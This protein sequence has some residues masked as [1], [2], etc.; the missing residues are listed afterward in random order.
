ME[1]SEL[2]LWGADQSAYLADLWNSGTQQSVATACGVS[3]QVPAKSHQIERRIGIT[4][5]PLLTTTM[6]LIAEMEA[7][8][9]CPAGPARFYAQS[10]FFNST[11]GQYCQMNLYMDGQQLPGDHARGESEGAGMQFQLSLDKQPD[12]LCGL[13]FF[14]MR[15]NEDTGA[16]SARQDNRHM[17]VEVKQ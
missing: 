17:Y 12:V 3:G 16:G 5:G 11:A 15:G 6:E 4:S 13:H 10:I 9:L 14:E 7:F 8:M 2:A 1:V